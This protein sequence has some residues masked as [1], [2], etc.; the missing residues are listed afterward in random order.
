MLLRIR[1]PVMPGS[2]GDPP[3]P[4][5][6]SEAVGSTGSAPVVPDS[7]P[8]PDC[9]SDRR[10]GH[11]FGSLFSSAEPTPFNATSRTSFGAGPP[12][13]P[14]T[15]TPERTVG[16]ARLNRRRFASDGAIASSSVPGGT[17]ALEEIPSPLNTIGTLVSVGGSSAGHAVVTSVLP[18]LYVP[19]S[20]GFFVTVM[21]SGERPA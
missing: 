10:Y 9:I 21:T 11:A 6:V 1:S 12:T 18:A 8:V 14:G 4:I 19:A 13:M 2:D 7:V 5:V 20:A 15:A 16:F 3:V 17:E